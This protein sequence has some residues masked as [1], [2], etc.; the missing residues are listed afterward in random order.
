MS[1]FNNISVANLKEALAIKEQIESLEAQ[2][3]EIMGGEMPVPFV[4]KPKKGRGMSA[5]GRA[6]VA[7]AQT[8][9]WA[10]V[11]GEVKK[12]EKKKR[13]KMSKAVRAKMAAAAKERWKKAKAAGK[14]RL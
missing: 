12:P 3:A 11:K 8:A 13:K 5:A 1:K 9:R 7:A 6:R 10:K 14:S 4:I 2:L